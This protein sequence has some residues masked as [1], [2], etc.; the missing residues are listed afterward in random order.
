MHETILTIIW[1]LLGIISS[2]AFAKS[3]EIA[4][5]TK[6]NDEEGGR[7]L[8]L[9]WI[10]RA[11]II[12]IVSLVLIAVIA[13]SHFMAVSV[14]IG[15]V[16]SVC[17]ILFSAILRSNG[18]HVLF[19]SFLYWGCIFGASL[20][21]AN[22]RANHVLG[23]TYTVLQIICLGLLVLFASIPNL[24]SNI[25][26]YIKENRDADELEDEKARALSR[27]DEKDGEIDDE[28]I[29]YEMEQRKKFYD[30]LICVVT[31]ILIIIVILV[32]AWL[33]AKYN[34]LPPYGD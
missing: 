25:K 26:E 31:A 23:V 3:L 28:L 11:V 10:G 2:L 9:G 1:L 8:E 6:V 32:L 21:Y 24:V 29:E 34:I 30:R 17:L 33:E 20:T 15:L 22:Y 7:S 27:D 16:L 18:I 12:A 13:L 4:S 19:S 14:I 5:A